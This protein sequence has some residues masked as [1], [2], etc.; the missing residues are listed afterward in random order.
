MSWSLWLSL[1]VTGDSCSLSSRICSGHMILGSLLSFRDGG[2]MEV[3]SSVHVHC[4]DCRG[5]LLL[6]L[7]Q[8]HVTM[9]LLVTIWE[10]EMKRQYHISQC[11]ACS[12]SVEGRWMTKNNE[13]EQ[14]AVTSLGHLAFSSSRWC[15]FFILCAHT[16]WLLNCTSLKLSRSPGVNILA[17]T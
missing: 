13:R 3:R 1:S 7:C 11:L 8:E 12:A 5:I 17:R 15:K 16:L 14:R 6:C 4:A 10:G 2:L 9:L